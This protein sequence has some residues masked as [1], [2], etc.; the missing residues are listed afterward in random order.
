MSILGGECRARSPWCPEKWRTRPRKPWKEPSGELR[1]GAKSAASLSDCVPSLMCR[2]ACPG[3]LICGSSGS[4]EVHMKGPKHP[5]FIPTKTRTSTA[6]GRDSEVTVTRQD[7]GCGSPCPS[8]MPAAAGWSHSSSKAA[9]T[10][11]PG[12]RRRG[13]AA[14]QPQRR[15][16]RCGGG[17]SAAAPCLAPRKA[18]P[19]CCTPAAA[20]LLAPQRKTTSAHLLLSASALPTS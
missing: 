20:T 16:W 6:T 3:R 17:A 12:K 19:C 18:L 10:P 15:S 5:D 2:L 14:A 8:L 7:Y 11:P 13:Y 4:V 1:I 9:T